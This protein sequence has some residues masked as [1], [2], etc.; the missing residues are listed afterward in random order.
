MDTINTDEEVRPH[1]ND[2]NVPCVFCLLHVSKYTCPRCNSNYCSVQCYKSE[3]HLQCSESFYKN[4]VMEGLS[5]YMA[6]PEER[7]K[8][9][10]TL[11]RMQDDDDGYLD[12][13]DED[14][15][16]LL[17]RL[18]G[19]NLDSDTDKIW[20]KLTK[21]EKEEFQ[22]MISNG[23][24]GGIIEIWTPWWN[25][26]DNRKVKDIEEVEKNTPQSPSIRENILNISEL[27][28]N[29]QP[30]VNIKYT[31][32][33]VLY[34]YTYIC[35]LHNGDHLSTPTDSAKAL[36]ELCN[37][38]RTTQTH[39]SVS[40]A[41]QSCLHK[42]DGDPHS[43]QISPKF[44]LFLIQDVIRIIEGPNSTPSVDYVMAAF[45]DLLR[46]WQEAIQEI[47]KDLK[48]AKNNEKLVSALKTKK[49]SFFRIEKKVQFLLSWCKSYGVDL[50]DS[51][52]ELN[53]EF[54]ALSSEMA[55]VNN[56]KHQF[57]KMWGGKRPAKKKILIEE[58]T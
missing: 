13:D 57:E 52:D 58:L 8:M 4:C 12:S 44:K 45:S 15:A 21:S 28:R 11:K 32:V 22:K 19:L 41:I 39:S 26:K 20:E 38:L 46:L 29:C 14:E 55:S 51:L 27:L 6:S 25:Y 40:E 56:T 47:S 10:E 1:I 48:K 9:V 49:K 30:S 53:L 5:D 3:K 36:L 17:D 18:Q 24:L 33:S 50:Q 31:V 42:A 37:A 35:R 7:H 16:D 34:A 2:K 54:C 23:Q 43:S